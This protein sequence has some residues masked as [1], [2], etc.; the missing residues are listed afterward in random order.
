MAP[1]DTDRRAERE[2]RDAVERILQR[3]G[4]L[5]AHALTGEIHQA[6]LGRFDLR[7]RSSTVYCPNHPHTRMPRAVCAHQESEMTSPRPACTLCL[8]PLDPGHESARHDR[9]AEH[10]DGQLQ[11]IPALYAALHDV[12]EPGSSDGTRVSGTRTA[13]LPLRVEPL[14]LLC[15]GGIVSILATWETDWRERRGFSR[16]PTTADCEQLLEGDNV[17]ADVVEFL[18]T[19]LDWAAR[20]HPAV[21]EFAGEIHEIIGACKSALGLT[22]DLRRIGQCPGQLGDRVCGRVLYADPY[23]AEIICDRCRTVWPRSRWLLLGAAIA[24]TAA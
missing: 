14:S 5:I 2:V 7:A 21:D 23:A 11:R 3:S 18:R 13:R 24:E 16:D 9:C 8:R 15:R 19:H 20:Q 12:L 4:C 1:A 17:L 10:L 22:T 6:Y